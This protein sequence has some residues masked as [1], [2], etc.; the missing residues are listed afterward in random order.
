[1]MQIQVFTYK[2]F[3]CKLYL[4]NSGSFLK[5]EAKYKEI[6]ILKANQC[7]FLKMQLLEY[8]LEDIS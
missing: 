4:H 6:R 1:M 8:R 7:V 2:G 5:E 3:Q